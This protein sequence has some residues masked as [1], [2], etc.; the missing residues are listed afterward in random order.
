MLEDTQL[1]GMCKRQLVRIQFTLNGHEAE[2]RSCGLCDTRALSIDGVPV[3][4]DDLLAGMSKG[5][6]VPP[7]SSDDESYMDEFG[8][9][10]LPEPGPVEKRRFGRRKDDQS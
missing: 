6:W 10:S 2:V 3:T 4:K 5:A 8:G 9:G 1:C 7:T